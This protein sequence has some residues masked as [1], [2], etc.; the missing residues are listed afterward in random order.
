MIF[1]HGK[2][3]DTEINPGPVELMC[4][5]L[6]QNYYAVSYFVI[7]YYNLQKKSALVWRWLAEKLYIKS[8]ITQ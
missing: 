3:L 2:Q 4:R 8:E 5:P 1:G 6:T 7:A